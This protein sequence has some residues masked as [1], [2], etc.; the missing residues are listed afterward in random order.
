ML[1]RCAYLSIPYFSIRDVEIALSEHGSYVKATLTNIF[2]FTNHNSYICLHNA[3][4]YGNSVSVHAVV[5]H[6]GGLYH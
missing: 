4:C 3:S 1:L 2:S 6:G 5:L